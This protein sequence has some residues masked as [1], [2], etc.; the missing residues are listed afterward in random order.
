MFANFL[1]YMLQW[2]SHAL[3]FYGCF[4]VHKNLHK[5]R[6][7]DSGPLIIEDPS[8]HFAGTVPRASEHLSEN[9]LQLFPP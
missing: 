8:A 1:G 4:R 5:K 9:L 6:K 7:C 2:C 3:W